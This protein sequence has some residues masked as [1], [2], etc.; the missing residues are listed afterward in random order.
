[1]PGGVD[2]GCGDRTLS[3]P[4]ARSVGSYEVAWGVL[5]LIG[6]PDAQITSVASTVVGLFGY[7]G[8][9]S[10]GST[11]TTHAI[12]NGNKRGPVNAWT[13]IRPCPLRDGATVTYTITDMPTGSARTR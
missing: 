4:Q 6:D 12:D 10:G 13:I 9:N 1:V 5:C 3:D 2:S 11:P 7:G 8:V